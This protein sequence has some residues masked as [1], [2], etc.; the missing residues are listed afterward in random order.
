MRN[1]VWSSYQPV[2]RRSI[3]TVQIATEITCLRTR[4]YA[5]TRPQGSAD[6]TFK[7]VKHDVWDRDLPAAPALVRIRRGETQY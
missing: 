5:S 2:R 1:A 4:C 3:F 6:G 7:F